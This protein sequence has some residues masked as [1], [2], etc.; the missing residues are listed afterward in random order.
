MAKN[1]QRIHDLLGL[2][3]GL[4]PQDLAEDWDNVGLQVGDSNLPLERVMV[5]LD[6]SRAAIRA[7]HA[8][9]AQVLVTH[10]PLLFKPLKRLTPDDAVG[11]IIWEA[12][13]AGIA[14]ISAHTNLDSASD[15]LNDWLASRLGLS[16][17][18]P[19][20]PAAGHWLKLV[21][22]V[23]V[24]HADAVAEALF[25]GG[26]GRV[27]N[28]DRCAFRSAGTGSFRPG[29]GTTPFVGTVGQDEQVDELRLETIVP[30][31]RLGRVLERLF[32]A[33]P[34][35][36]VAYDLIPLANQN[37]QAGLGRIGRLEQPLALQECGA[38]IKSALVTP[39]LRVVGD[40]SRRIA[41]VAV[42]GGSG[43]G[44]VQTAHRQGADLLVTGDVKYH[45]ARLAEDLGLAV[46][47]AGHFAT[48]QL[49]VAGL[50][51][52]LGAAARARGWEVDFL[53]YA[54]ETDPFRVV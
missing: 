47:D 23:P 16:Q 30:Q 22:F 20:L 10:H 5:A 11:G 45:E 25:A 24:G 21:V 34:Y 28:Y 15:G 43:G 49:A 33:H 4:Y 7:A 17:T 36:E 35:E 51:A 40:P 29:D 26:A 14:I 31:A 44:L 3:H 46:I 6:P 27:G 32:K 13:Q 54:D 18:Q 9:D 37:S 12:V 39:Q 50:V 53:A 2:I 52:R 42:C 48:E 38:M 19:L 41:K 1:R 8:A